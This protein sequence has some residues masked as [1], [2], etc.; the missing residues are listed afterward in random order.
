MVSGLLIINKPKGLTSHDVVAQIRR[1]T[2]QRKAGHTGT[3]DP[4]AT[5]VLV[6]CLGQATRLIEY[7]VAARKQYRA[8]IRFG[9][10]T[11]TLDADGQVLT[12]TDIAGLTA[13]Q[14]RAALPAFT[15]Q[16]EQRP[17]MYSAIKQDGQPLYKR[18]RAGQTVDIPPR[19]VTIFQLD[20][21]D[22]QPPD[23]TLEVTCS[24]GTYIRSLARDLGQAAGT[25]AHLAELARTAN[26][27]W[28]LAQAT[29]L[30][31]L[32]P[33]N[34][35]ESLLPVDRA[36]AHLP[37]VA[38]APDNTEHVRHGRQI[39]LPEPSAPGNVLAAFTSDNTFLA[40]LARTEDNGW[41]PKKVFHS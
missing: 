40:I 38:L 34:W 31:S 24:A 35:R 18:A 37:R 8:V 28:T 16:I 29:A 20:W 9:V 5:G 39:E 15:G 11:D 10:T 19:P 12:Q 22:W 21:L 27:D 4:M 13:D 30:E 41:Q 3:L 33:A 1:I 2:G 25:G 6:V 26:G 32:T 36:V 17:P 7:I 14:L 23:L